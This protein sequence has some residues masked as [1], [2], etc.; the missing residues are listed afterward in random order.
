MS[1]EKYLVVLA[2][3]VAT[4]AVVAHPVTPTPRSIGLSE[5][6]N[7]TVCPI[8]V[9]IDEDSTRI[10]KKIKLLKCAPNPQKWCRHQHI[11]DNECCQHNHDNHVMECVEITDTVLVY[12]PTGPDDTSPRRETLTVQVGCTCMIEPNSRAVTLQAPT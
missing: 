7:R 6:I 10:P 8:Q 11:P 4:A 1:S 9:E 5:A 2:V 3:V 12:Y